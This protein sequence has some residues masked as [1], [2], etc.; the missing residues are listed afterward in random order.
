MAFEMIAIHGVPLVPPG[1]PPPLDPG[2]RP[3]VLANR[4]FRGSIKQGGIPVQ[5]ALERAD[6]SVSRFDL[7]MAP[8]GTPQAEGNFAYLER[9]LK[10][11]LWSRGGCKLYFAGPAELAGR[12][13]LHY[14]NSETGRFDACIMGEKIYEKPFELVLLPAEEL[15]VE[16]EFT[17]ALGRHLDG[18]RIGF[19]LGASDRKVAALLDGK[20]VFSE[21]AP[22]DPRSHAD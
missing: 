11:L 13:E 10:F 6:G 3:A 12:L 1:V 22:W 20:T 19:D 14:R 15:P 16:R 4:A 8:A 18:C 9:L 5:V 17:A 2:F 21:E 7:G